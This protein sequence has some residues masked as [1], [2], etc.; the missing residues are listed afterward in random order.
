MLQA[1]LTLSFAA[2]PW[3]DFNAFW[4]D[5]SWRM[6]IVVVGAVPSARRLRAAS[7]NSV[8]EQAR[9]RQ[10]TWTKF[11]AVQDPRSCRSRAQRSSR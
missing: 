11:F 4:D 6:T 8:L 1:S 2:A 9:S 5:P 7:Q 3:F 10:N